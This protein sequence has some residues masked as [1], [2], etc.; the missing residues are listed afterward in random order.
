M[1]YVENYNEIP[2]LN[3]LGIFVGTL[4]QQVLALLL[5]FARF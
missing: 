5:I 1:I 2:G 3:E 4:F